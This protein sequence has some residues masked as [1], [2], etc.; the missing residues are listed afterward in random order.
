MTDKTAVIEKGKE[1]ATE[2]QYKKTSMTDKIELKN[3]FYKL[4]TKL[5]KTDSKTQQEVLKD[6]I[7]AV[8]VFSK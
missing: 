2:Y 1:Y 3:A 8:K 7:L 5:K 4:I 6:W